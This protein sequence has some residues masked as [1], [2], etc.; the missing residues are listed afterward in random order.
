MTQ[1]RFKK[2][3]PT[4]DFNDPAILT[5]IPDEVKEVVPE[6]KREEP[7][8]VKEEKLVAVKEEKLVAVKEEK[9]LLEML[10]KKAE[11]SN[12]T[13]YLDREVVWKIDEMAKASGNSRSKVANTLL[14][15]MLFDN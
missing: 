2:S 12:Y 11:G 4:V 14:R 9:P 10:G 7:V 13:L 3:A 5:V 6:P 8:A 15:K 1:N